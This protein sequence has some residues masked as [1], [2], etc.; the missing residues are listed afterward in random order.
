MT[1]LPYALHMEKTGA[2]LLGKNLQAERTKTIGMAGH[3]CRGVASFVLWLG[4][5]FEAALKKKRN[6][7]TPSVQM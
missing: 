7:P 4:R 5:T 6:H 1:D 2:L 3:L